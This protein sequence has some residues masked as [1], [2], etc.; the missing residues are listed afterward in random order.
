VSE[1]EIFYLIPAEGLVV[2]DPQTAQ[3]LPE[4]GARVRRTRYWLRRVS[5]G[6]CAIG[7]PP[8]EL[9]ESDAAEPPSEEG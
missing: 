9:D 3:P 6:S 4:K 7:E 1:S 8:V 2:L 5:E